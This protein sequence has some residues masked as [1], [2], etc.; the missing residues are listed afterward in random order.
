MSSKPSLSDRIRELDAALSRSDYDVER[1]WCSA[2]RRLTEERNGDGAFDDILAHPQLVRAPAHF[3][4]TNPLEDLDVGSLSALYEFVLASNDMATKRKRGQFFTPNDVSHF[5][6]QK[7]LRFPPGVW[8]D[9]CCGTGNLSHALVAVQ[10]DPEDFLMNRLLCSDVDGLALLTARVL[11]ALS[12][13]KNH[14]NLFTAIEGN[15]RQGDFLQQTDLLG[16]YPFRE[17]YDFVLMNPPYARTKDQTG[18]FRSSP[19]GDLFAYFME[20]AATTSRGYVSITP[21]VF[22]NGRRHS[23]LREVILE[24]SAQL[25]IYC[26]DNVPDTV[27]RG[28]KYGSENSNQVNSTRAAIT[29]SHAPPL[30]NK[31][32]APEV[33]VTPLLR[34]KAAERSELFQRADEFLSAPL[35]VNADLIPKVSPGLEGLYHDLVSSSTSLGDLLSNKSG[36]FSLSVPTTPRYFISAVERTLNRSS[37]RHLGFE[38]LDAWIRAYLVLN[39]SLAYFWWRVRDGGMTLSQHTLLSTPIPP[40]I[41]CN[42]DEVKFLL[43]QLRHS[44]ALNLVTKMNAGRPNE[45]VKHPLELIDRL[46]TLLLPTYRHKLISLHSNSS[47]TSPGL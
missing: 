39:S 6:A 42:S 22:T 31:G 29:V 4:D 1:T 34:W 24:S 37:Q 36:E 5:M 45:N 10:D 2:L 33:S 43:E 23:A 19:S 25:S 35:E 3:P 26:F 7:T 27:F 28:L 13:Q 15:F 17:E 38:T 20:I 14:P 32:K 18:L 16:E 47:L 9:P 12:F 30:T 40:Q 21:Q 41:D 8:L 46:N 11:K 44:E